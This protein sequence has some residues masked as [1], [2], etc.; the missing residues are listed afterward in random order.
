MYG[1]LE[2]QFRMHYKEIK[3]KPGVTGDLLMARLEM[4]LDNVVKRMGFASS[5]IQARQ[6][7]THGSFLVN[8]KK[9]TIPSYKMKVGDVVGVKESKKEKSYF[10]LQMQNLGA[11]KDFPRWIEFNAAKMEGKIV[12]EVSREDIEVRVDPQMVVESYSR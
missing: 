3:N 9:V 5:P 12:A 11:K 4:R 7:V 10:K 6:L 2:R 1:I 8:G